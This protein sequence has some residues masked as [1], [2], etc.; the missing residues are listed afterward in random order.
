M[1]QE[2]YTVS[3]AIQAAAKRLIV[4]PA[5]ESVNQSTRTQQ[6]TLVNA[7]LG[8]SGNPQGSQGGN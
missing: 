3:M 8:S 7:G 5:R 6:Q 4:D 1:Q 2:M